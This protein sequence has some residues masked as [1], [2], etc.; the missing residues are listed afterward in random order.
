Y[1]D[2]RYPPD[3]P[4]KYAHTTMY[5]TV[6]ASR[7]IFMVLFENIVV[8]LVLLISWAIPDIPSK[9]K[10]KIRREAHMVNH[11]MLEEARKTKRHCETNNTD[12]EAKGDD[13]KN[14]N[15]HRPSNYGEISE[16]TV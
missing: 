14:Q 16:E 7:L 9:L 6:L 12:S 8:F 10:D 3:D 15:V 1:K 5:W 4:N 11:I 13:Y 2:Y